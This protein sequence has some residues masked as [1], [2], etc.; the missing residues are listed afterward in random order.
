MEK[1]K[2]NHISIT[3]LAKIAHPAASFFRIRY[4]ITG[5]RWSIMNWHILPARNGLRE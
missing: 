5:L 1:V 2:E 4:L 3:V